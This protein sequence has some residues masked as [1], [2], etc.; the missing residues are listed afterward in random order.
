MEIFKLF[1]SI[2]IDDKEANKSL[3]KIEEKTGN[4]TE[5]LGKGIKTAGK[6]GVG[7]AAGAGVA[8]AG[9]GT[10][11]SKAMETTN[12]INK[13]SEVTGMS[14]KGFQEWDYVAKQF[15]FSM[16]D[17][18]GDMAMLAER[19]MDAKSG[20]G[21]NAKMFK[22]LGVSV[23][24]ANGQLKS[25]EQLF[26]EVITGLQGMENSTERNA[27]A[28]A[29]LS[30]TGEELAP[31]LNMSNKEL[32]KMKGN[33]NVISNENLNKA[34]Q[35]KQKWQKAK[36]TLT[37]V[38]TEIGI[39]LMPI[40]SKMLDWIMEH[41]PQIQSTFKVVFS[42]IGS[43]I[44]GFIDVIQI[45]I[46]WLKDM[47]SGNKETLEGMKAKF[48]EIMPKLR[49]FAEKA[50]KAVINVAKTMYKFWK[51][52][53]LPIYVQ[54]F[55]W[56]RSYMP[57]VKEF[58]KVAFQ[59]IIDIV[60]IAWDIFKNDL[61]PILA[62]FYSTIRENLPQIK[63][64]FEKVFGIIF[65][66]IET[67]WDILDASLIPVIKFLWE[68]VVQPLLPKLGKVI[69]DT[70]SIIIDIIEETIEIFDDVVGAIQE[71]IDKL[72]FWNNTD[73]EEK[74][75]KINEESHYTDSRGRPKRYATGTNY[76]PTNEPFIAGENGAELVFGG[77]GSKVKTAQ[78]TK[79]MLGGTTVNHNYVTISAK[80]VKEFNEVTDFFNQ[81][82]QT[83]KAN[84]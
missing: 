72:T 12:E 53:L 40:F 50:F 43:V 3:S 62:G 26:N 11:V 52:N 80:D 69:E 82:P 58:A 64:I 67:V 30:T 75:L 13:F 38:V 19:A 5:K 34:E 42:V 31:V 65:K 71:G 7:V 84:T 25:Q 2:F 28:T 4:F 10:L 46:K 78:E 63:K 55:E 49:N 37:T 66:V 9:L 15:G 48:S 8:A 32:K 68:K 44:R 21:E 20:V 27:I 61:L 70:F 56:I 16:Q 47:F 54:L 59:K 79:D 23:T 57:K 45:T 14:K 60:K 1:G 76:H 41:M 24:G 74:T 73:P 35:F 77:K 39:K 17:A 83:V 81:L 6:L 51:E 33:A 36:A 22:R 18:S 29:M